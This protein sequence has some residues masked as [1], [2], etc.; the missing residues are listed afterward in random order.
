MESSLDK[1]IVGSYSIRQGDPGECVVC[2]NA[3][4]ATILVKTNEY[5]KDYTCLECLLRKI[6]YYAAIEVGCSD[7]EA[8]VIAYEDPNKLLDGYNYEGMG[9]KR[10]RAKMTDE[11]AKDI[12]NRRGLTK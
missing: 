11:E 9:I 5:G 4:W 7:Y 12:E 1:K 6:E 8:R 10:N 2:H 3:H